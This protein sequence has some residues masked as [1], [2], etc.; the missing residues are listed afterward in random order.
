M[1]GHHFDIFTP[2]PVHVCEDLHDD[3]VDLGDEWRNWHM[4][5]SKLEG[6]DETEA[7]VR[8]KRRNKIMDQGVG[9][10]GAGSSHLVEG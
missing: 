2:T 9:K 10:G 3:E 4:D 8:K 7:I 1:L 5:D 6:D